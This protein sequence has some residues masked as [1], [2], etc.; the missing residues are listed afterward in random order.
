[1]IVPMPLLSLSRISLTINT[2]PILRDVSFDA[3]QGEVKRSEE[4]REICA[5]ADP[6]T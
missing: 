1:M 3:E 5:G 2:Q 4:P 6:T